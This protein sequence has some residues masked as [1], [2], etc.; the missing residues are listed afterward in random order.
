MFGD[1]ERFVVISKTKEKA[2]RDYCDGDDY[3]YNRVMHWTVKPFLHHIA[4]YRITSKFNAKII[5]SITQT[6]Y[7][8]QFHVIY[9]NV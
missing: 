2:K 4:A 3:D 1:D 7:D 9:K 6:R 8:L 5:N